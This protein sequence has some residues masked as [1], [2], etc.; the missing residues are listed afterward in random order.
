MD[1]S[2]R[3]GLQQRIYERFKIF[4]ESHP[5][6]TFTFLGTR[7]GGFIGYPEDTRTHFDP[8]KRGWYKDAVANKDKVI[9]TEPYIDYTTQALVVSLAKAIPGT[10]GQIVGVVAVDIKNDSI[11]E[12][13]KKL[14]VGE[15]GYMV[16]IHKSGIVIADAGNPSN[17]MKKLSETYLSGNGHAKAVLNEAHTAYKIDIK[18][19]AYQVNTIKF[20]TSD[21]IIM[22]VREEKELH[23]GANAARNRSLAIAALIV[24]VACVLSFLM[25]SRIVKPINIMMKDLAAFEGDLTMRFK[26]QSQDEIGELTKWFNVFLEKLQT[27]LRGVYSE[28]ES[29]SH[30]A[31]NLESIS[32]ILLENAQG[33]STRA[34]TVASAAEEMNMNINTV[35]AAMKQ[36]SDNANMVAAATKEMNADIDQIADTIH[37]AA[38]ITKKGVNQAQQTSAQMSELDDAAKSISEVTN[39]ITE[40]SEQTNLLALNATIE[41]AR[42]GEAGKG[43]AVVANEIKELASQAAGATADIRSKITRIQQTSNSSIGAINDIVD[44]INNINTVISKITASFDHQSTNTKKISQNIHQ[45]SLGLAEV[46]DSLN[47][48]SIVSASINEEIGGVNVAAGEIVERGK[49]LEQQAELLNTLADSLKKLVGVF[50]I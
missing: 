24:F 23:A 8:R 5:G 41:A 9:Q 4:G 27:L 7:Y 14:T 37:S 6:T 44:I 36:S 50:N 40:I 31:G 34:N 42:A 33:T 16:L 12:V 49:E 30:S 46:N 19:T 22:V 15:T 28:T 26:V 38:K 11:T 17:N 18:D 39:T 32:T 1:S 48:N 3:G 13:A 21:W 45:V 20:D 2:R 10:D 47:Q 25:A 43:F 29:V 35:A